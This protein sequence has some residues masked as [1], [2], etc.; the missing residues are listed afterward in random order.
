MLRFIASL[1]DITMVVFMNL[2]EKI[3][4]L[5]T[6]EDEFGKLQLDVIRVL[7]IF[8]GVL[9]M[10]EIIPDIMKIHGHVMDYLPT[11]K[12]LEKVLEKLEDDGIINVEVRERGMMFS[13]GVYKD[14]LVKLL[15]L[16]EARTLLTS[17][18]VYINYL[19]RKM[20]MLRRALQQNDE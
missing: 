7:T 12:M 14:K 19:S 18:N 16:R 3:E 11:E 8:N 17:D 6:R 1:H 13:K 15:N 20:K 2:K 5:K 9:W 4:K 10:S